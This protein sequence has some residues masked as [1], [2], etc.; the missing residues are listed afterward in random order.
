MTVKF[1]IFQQLFP[2][3]YFHRPIEVKYTLWALG[4][5]LQ[6][7]LKHEHILRNTLHIK[8][9]PDTESIW[10]NFMLLTEYKTNLLIKQNISK[11]SQ[12][13]IINK[14]LRCLLSSNTY[15]VFITMWNLRDCFKIGHRYVKFGFIYIHYKIKSQNVPL[16][17]IPNFHLTCPTSSM[18]LD[19]TCLHFFKAK[20]RILRN[21]QE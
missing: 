15:V 3:Q 13:Q 4:T 19:T 1:T 9:Y 14:S 17:I 10:A 16:P 12:K 7:Y 5:A 21:N 2:F 20:H 18:E 6:P 11:A 8:D